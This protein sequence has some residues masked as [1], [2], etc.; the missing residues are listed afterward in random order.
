[1]VGELASSFPVVQ[2]ILGT[3]MSCIQSEIPTGMSVLI[4]VAIVS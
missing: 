3:V 2:G 4:L 1:M